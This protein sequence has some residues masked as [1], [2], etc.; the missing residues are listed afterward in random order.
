MPCI[1][2]H[3]HNLKYQHDASGR[4]DK[5]EKKERKATAIKNSVCIG[6]AV[7]IYAVVPNGNF[8]SRYI[9]SVTEG[10]IPAFDNPGI[11]FT[12][13]MT[14]LAGVTTAIPDDK[15]RFSWRKEHR[16]EMN[17]RIHRTQHSHDEPNWY[18]A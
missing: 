1:T 12:V 16:H 13:R 10:Q 14:A 2:H 3:T 6:M 5:A 4:Q 15:H 11:S 9:I 7:K 18:H 8:F 17:N